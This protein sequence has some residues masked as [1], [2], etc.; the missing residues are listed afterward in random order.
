M[1]SGEFVRTIGE[2]AG[3]WVDEDGDSDEMDCP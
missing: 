2:F 3:E 1:T